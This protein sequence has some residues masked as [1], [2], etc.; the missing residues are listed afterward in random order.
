MENLKDKYLLKCPVCGTNYMAEPSILM[1]VGTNSGDAYCQNCN[2]Y[3]HIWI[4][5]CGLIME[6]ETWDDFLERIRYT[7]QDVKF[8][9]DL[10]KTA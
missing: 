6:A 8:F 1:K 5:D 10:I 7:E 4:S 9:E 2:T 3:L